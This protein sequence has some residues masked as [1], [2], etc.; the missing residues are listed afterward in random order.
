MV[1]EETGGISSARDI[2]TTEEIDRDA[3]EKDY[4]VQHKIL[5]LL[6]ILVGISLYLA[7]II[8]F[9]LFILVSLS[10]AAVISFP[11]RI[12]FA[13][14][15]EFLQFGLIPMALIALAVVSNLGNKIKNIVRSFNGG[16]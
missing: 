10:F 2:R 5:H 8:Y 13:I 4:Q 12:D 7:T 6:R 11:Y 15:L 3:A 9:V 1:V 14:L 16:L